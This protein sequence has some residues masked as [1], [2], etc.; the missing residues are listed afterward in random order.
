MEEAEQEGGGVIIKEVFSQETNG[1]GTLASVLQEQK[2]SLSF[3]Y[4]LIHINRTGKLQE[5]WHRHTTMEER[6]CIL[7]IHYLYFPNFF[8]H[9]M[10]CCLCN[11]C[12]LDTLFKILPSYL[13]YGT[14]H[15]KCWAWELQ[16]YLSFKSPLWERH[17]IVH[18]FLNMFKREISP[19]GA[20]WCT[21][22]SLS[23]NWHSLFFP[24]C[25]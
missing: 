24:S 15:R 20:V 23:F 11:C 14:F 2:G 18:I 3:P 17:A 7:L 13:F 12:F 25:I 16:V 9:R 19:K 10:F 6:V 5:M 4:C 22:L 8:E 21:N 1:W